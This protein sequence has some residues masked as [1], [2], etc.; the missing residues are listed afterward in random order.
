MIIESTGQTKNESNIGEFLCLLGRNKSESLKAIQNEFFLKIHK[1]PK[2]EHPTT[3]DLIIFLNMVLEEKWDVDKYIH[4]DELDKFLLNMEKSGMRK[5]I[6]LFQHESYRK[7][8][9]K[10]HAIET[11]TTIN[12][13]TDTSEIKESF[14]DRILPTTQA[15]SSLTNQISKVR[16]DRIPKIRFNLE[17]RYLFSLAKLR[18]P[19]PFIVEYVNAKM[20]GLE[21]PVLFIEGVLLHSELLE[22]PLIRV[23]VFV[24]V[25]YP[26]VLKKAVDLN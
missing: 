10:C 21:N 3:S 23:I 12:F 13:Y 26:M 1:S 25:M 18:N 6:Y 2:S 19:N 9:E 14:E 15:D 11:E 5:E 17:G 16:S 4:L 24:E 22:D 20:L 7:K 8:C